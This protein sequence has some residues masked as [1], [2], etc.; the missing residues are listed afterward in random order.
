M[1]FP[2]FQ[3]RWLKLWRDLQ[4]EKERMVVM[5]VAITVSLAA[6]GAVM[7]GYAVLSREMAANYLGTQPACATLELP[8]GVDAAAL[9]IARRHP[10]LQE[11]EA[12]DVVLARAQVNGDWRALLLFVVDDF[13]ALRLNLFKPLAGDWPPPPGTM[14]I[15]HTA[16]GMLDAGVGGRVRVKTAHGVAQDIPVT[17][18]VH[19]PGLAPAW[20]ERSGYGYISRATLATLGELPLLHELR[21]TLRDA[22][23]DGAMIESVAAD[24]ARQLAESGQ[25]VHEIRVPPPRRHPHQRQMTTILFLMLAF[26]LMALLLSGVL[27]ASSLAAML[28]R[29]VREIGVMKALG[30]QEGQIVRLYA[31][32]VAALGAVG[33]LL[34]APLGLLGATALANAVA[35]LLNLTIANGQVPA[36]VF[37]VQTVAGMLV[38]LTI[39]AL[40]IR[41]ASRIS[42]RQAMEQHGAATAPLRLHLARLPRPLRDALRR[43]VRLALT[44]VLLAMGGAMFMTALN[45]SKSWERT[46]AKVYET[47]HY[48]VE[49]RFHEPQGGAV[50]RR[51]LAVAGVASAEAWGYS[52]AAYAQA[53][54]IDVVH[55]YPDRG[56]ASFSMLAPPPDTRLI[57]FP[58]IAGRWLEQGDSDAVVLNH[59][60]AAQVPQ[61]RVGDRI[62]LSSDGKVA[63][64]L[65]VGI[66]EE[67]GAAGVAYVTDAAFA[68]HMDT[69]GKTRLLRIA[70]RTDTPQAHSEIIRAIEQ[71]LAADG[72]S[73][74]SALPLSELRTAMADHIGILIRALLAMAAV[75]ATVGGLGL[76]S[77]MSVSVL[78]RTREFA[79]LKT[80]GATPA[81]ILRLVGAESLA[82]ALLSWVAALILAIPLTVLVDT[83]VGNLGFVAPLPL[84]IAPLPALAWLALAAVLS[85]AATLLPAR[86]AARLSVA[87]GV[88]QL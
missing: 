3:M 55:T 63:T 38:P 14:L 72:V 18:L 88:V 42:V 7:G 83:L 50:A 9:A 49:V 43:P 22:T 41:R 69:Q 62:D 20:Q 39:A 12:R 27:V 26:S 35:G 86:R 78:E 80:I 61:V 60:A 44:V 10:A 31:G 21:I 53:G 45:V 70:T 46:I 75:M 15:E 32:L 25:P 30:A 76:S 59:A 81:R 5:L 82:I 29:Q 64:W 1:R 73:V 47:R 19:D 2:I 65:V 37:A 66:V 85:L 4:A 71:R 36:W 52:P 23:A 6:V 79:V 51:V 33:V 24:L 56:H 40:P 77:A 8:A 58:L 57:A 84:I 28:A 48:D 13:D 11:A 74:E 16:T 67:I 54:K 87:E 34:A 17:G 68:R